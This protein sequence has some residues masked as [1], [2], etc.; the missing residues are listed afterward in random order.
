MDYVVNYCGFELTVQVYNVEEPVEAY[1]TGPWEDCYPA[2]DG[3]FDFVVIDAEYKEH[4][5]EFADI[6]T[7]FCQHELYEAIYEEVFLNK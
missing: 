7:S 6:A 2:E 3:Y 4:M 1:V 5:A